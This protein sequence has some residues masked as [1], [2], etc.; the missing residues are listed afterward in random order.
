MKLTLIT[1]ASTVVTLSFSLKKQ[2]IALDL[3]SCLHST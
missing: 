2:P 3:T 1:V